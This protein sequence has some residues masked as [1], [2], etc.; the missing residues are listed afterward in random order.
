MLK[1]CKCCNR[2]ISLKEA[3]SIWRK[4]TYKGYVCESCKTK[5]K[6][7][8]LSMVINFFVGWIMY[9]IV[10]MTNAQ[11]QRGFIQNV[12]YMSIIIFIVPIL[13]IKY[14]VVE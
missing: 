6:P 8:K 10:F 2:K 5:Y 12:I 3:F 11:I 4:N 7:T 13:I 9:M 14:D 1:S